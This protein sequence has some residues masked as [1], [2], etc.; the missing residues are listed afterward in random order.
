MS[1]EVRALMNGVRGMILDRRNASSADERA[2]PQKG[3]TPAK[4]GG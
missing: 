2:V 3:G 4:N 1:H